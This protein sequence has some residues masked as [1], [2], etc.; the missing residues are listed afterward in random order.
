MKMRGWRAWYVDGHAVTREEELG[1]GIVLA[2][3]YFDPPYKNIFNGADWLW[4]RAGQWGTAM[5]KD[6]APKDARLFA[7][8]LMR[9]EDFERLQIEAMASTWP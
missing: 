2:V 8:M 5:N 7:G 1:D 6:E 3:V 9:D 4:Y